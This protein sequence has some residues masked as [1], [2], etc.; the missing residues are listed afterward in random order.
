M[1]SFM[2]AKKK[3]SAVLTVYFPDQQIHY[4]YIHIYINNILYIVSTPTCFDASAPSRR[5]TVL[6]Y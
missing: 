2:P 5:L 3:S 4:I 6:I 1:Q